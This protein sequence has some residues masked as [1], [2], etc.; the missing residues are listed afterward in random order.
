[1]D[2][3]KYDFEFTSRAEQDLDDILNYIARD[4]A[5]PTA[6]KKFYF[7]LSNAIDNICLFPNSAPLSEFNFALPLRKLIVENYI[8]YYTID[9]EKRLIRIIRIQ[10]ARQDLTKY[11]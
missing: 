8:S 4:L 10:Y 6:A 11:F 5:N 1:M 9:E 7:A 2:S 3:C